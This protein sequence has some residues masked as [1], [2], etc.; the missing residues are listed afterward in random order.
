M[1]SY[2]TL[3][4]SDQGGN[5]IP[6]KISSCYLDGTNPTNI[7]TTKVSGVQHIS[8]DVY[9]RRIYWVD[10]DTRGVRTE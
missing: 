9:D 4:W 10:Q 7:I 1:F 5:G 6:A 3:Y 2:R 8:F